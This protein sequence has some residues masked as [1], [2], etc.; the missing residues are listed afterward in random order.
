MAS[1]IAVVGAGY[2]GKN[3]VRNFYNIGALRVI[4]DTSESMLDDLSNQYKNIK[5]TANLEEV[6]EDPEVKGVVIAAPAHVHYILALAALQSGKDVLVE[7]P[8]CLSVQEGEELC[9]LAEKRKCILMVGHLLHHHPAGNALK[10]AISSGYAGRIHQV[11]S[12]RLNLGRFRSEENVMWSF[13]PHDISLILSLV[14]AEPVCVS[15]T[16]TATLKPGIYDTVTLQMEFESGFRASILLSW[17]Y[18]LKEQKLVIVGDK[19]M[20]VFDDIQKEQKL[21][22]FKEP[23]RWNGSLPEPVRSE[24]EV[25]KVAGDEPLKQECLAFLRAVET[26]QAPETDGWEGLRVLKVLNA[27]QKSLLANG[28]RVQINN[29]D[30]SPA[31]FAHP[32]AVIDHPC[33]IGEGTRIWHFSHVMAGAVIGT[34]CNIGQNVVISPGVVLGRNV[35]VQNNVSVYTGVICEDDVFLGPSMVFTNIKNP[36]SHVPRRDQYVKTIIRRGATIGAN[37]TIVCGVEIG[38]YAMAGA[39]AVITKSVPP[40]ALVAGNPARQIG[41]VCRCG[42][43]IELDK[44]C[45]YCGFYLKKND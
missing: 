8:L 34:E 19:G 29:P 2:W 33:T 16:G 23:V 21:L 35:K 42:E 45:L 7:K 17:L 36:R 30:Y 44:Q 20:L 6:F 10:Q 1:G 41:W 22:Y 32:T 26:R 37:A 12:Y 14:K 40:Y 3:H 43:R 27:A 38:E 28:S 5:T 24:P 15:A 11:Y 31:Y 39:G 18:P 9:R 4:C 13:A 25:L